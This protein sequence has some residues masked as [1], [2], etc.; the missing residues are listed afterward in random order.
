MK[1]SLFFI[2]LVGLFA[3]LFN[4]RIFPL[5]TGLSCLYDP[6]TGKKVAILYDMHL[7]DLICRSD[8]TEDERKE[9]CSNLFK[10][11]ENNLKNLVTSLEKEDQESLF[12]GE[13]PSF[14]LKDPSIVGEVRKGTL[15]VVPET[16]IESG[17]DKIG[18]LTFT[19]ADPREKIDFAALELRFR[20]AEFKEYLEKKI[21]LEM[22][23][24]ITID[25]YIGH[26][27][28]VVHNL[29]QELDNIS[30][31]SFIA[32]TLKEKLNILSQEIDLYIEF[33][34]KEYN[35]KKTDHLTYLYEKELQFNNKAWLIN[36][37]L[38]VGILRFD[39]ELLSLVK[40]TSVKNVIIQTGASHSKFITHL[41]QKKGYKL[42]NEY[43]NT[44]DL[45][46]DKDK[47]CVVSN[48]ES[49]IMNDV[50]SNNCC[51]L[52]AI[53]AVQRKALNSVD[54]LIFNF[55]K[56]HSEEETN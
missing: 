34:L 30:L 3:C 9:S 51:T 44:D 21:D 47:G 6:Q 18:N 2:T 46:V 32:N 55:F 31:D 14:F 1:K 42:I 25:F 38:E 29:L 39:I 36:R 15:M 26:F 33:A 45:I 54:Q 53:Q 22:Y 23:A 12:L 56:D 49:S 20:V 43:G 50:Y 16:F 48:C 11:Q 8:L 40:D 10:Q 27:K 41:L 37:S 24:K 17:S 35:L 5:T 19:A 28:G 7:W 52:E 13:C 4:Q